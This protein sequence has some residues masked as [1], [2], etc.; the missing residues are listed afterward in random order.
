MYI[1]HEGEDQLHT[2]LFNYYTYSHIYWRWFWIDP[3]HIANQYLWKFIGNEEITSR[4]ENFILPISETVI[5]MKPNDH[6]ARGYQKR[7]YLY[8]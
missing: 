5:E 2:G 1:L 6:I 7:V 8:L 4:R 3:N